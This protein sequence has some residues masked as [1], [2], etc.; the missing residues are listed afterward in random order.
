MDTRSGDLW[1]GQISNVMRA[2]REFAINHSESKARARRE[3]AVNHSENKAKK[4]HW[5]VPKVLSRMGRPWNSLSPPRFLTWDMRYS[6]RSSLI[7]DISFYN[8]ICLKVDQK[9]LRQ[10][11]CVLQLLMLLHP[12]PR[13][14]SL[15]RDRD[16]SIKQSLIDAS[17][18]INTFG[19]PMG[20]LDAPCHSV[21][22]LKKHTFESTF[23]C[24]EHGSDDLMVGSITSFVL[25]ASLRQ[26][27][28]FHT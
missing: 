7:Q 20:K 17:V 6:R 13:S 26:N 21:A 3:F 23:G 1:T 24:M 12:A 28:K 5:A 22:W 8:S 14:S 10:I 18:S 25:C 15:H 16:G 9:L 11:W 19:T 2:S 27:A 4:T